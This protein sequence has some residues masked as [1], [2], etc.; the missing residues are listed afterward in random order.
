MAIKMSTIAASGVGSSGGSPLKQ[1]VRP[2]SATYRDPFR[3][4]TQPLRCYGSRGLICHWLLPAGFSPVW[5]RF[6][7]LRKGGLRSAHLPDVAVAERRCPIQHVVAGTGGGLTSTTAT[8]PRRC[9]GHSTSPR[10]SIA[11]PASSSIGQF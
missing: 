1:V 9:T 3:G 2:V 11:L 4:G 8:V 7:A 5:E 6:A 10:F